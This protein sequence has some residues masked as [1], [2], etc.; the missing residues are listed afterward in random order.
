MTHGKRVLL[1][2]E[3]DFAV[4]DSLKFS[5]ETEEFDVRAYATADE[6]LS[7]DSLPAA[8]CLIVHYN[9]P[10]VNGLDV[11][12]A[13]RERGYAMP[14]LLMTGLPSALV[15]KRAADAGVALVEKPFQGTE[16]IDCIHKLLDGHSKPPS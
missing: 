5:L 15:R 9:L 8:S 2:V 3:G 4:R 13:L 1:I 16:L 7:D 6:L 14:A 11:I 12:A 10:K